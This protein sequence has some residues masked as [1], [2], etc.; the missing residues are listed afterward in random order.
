MRMATDRRQALALLAALGA[1]PL[2]S[3]SAAAT[4][5]GAK[6][7]LLA[8]WQASDREHIGQVKLGA[9]EWA[10]QHVLEVPT[11]AHGLA[12]EAGG[13]VLAVARRPGDWL[14]RW[15]PATGTTQWHWMEED[16]RF[17]GHVAADAS[18]RH[19]WT[20]ETE[21]EQAQGLVGLRDARSLEKT[22]EWSTHG[23]DPHQL[24][25]LPESLG[26][27]S[28]GAL[29]V[30]NGG[31]MALPETGRTKKRLNEMDASLVVMDPAK[32]HLLGQWRLP[33]S[34]LSIRHLAW[35]PRHRRLGIALQ[36]E[37]PLA[38]ERHAAPVLAVWDGSSLRI[39]ANQPPMAGY[40][41]DIVALPAGG[42]AVSCPR[43][44]AIA[45]FGP[46]G[47]WRA[48]LSLPGAYALAREAEQWWAGGLPQI[49]AAG[50]ELLQA[51]S[52]LQSLRWD[53][54]WVPAA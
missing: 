28:A 46:D 22:S 33:D 39:A 54:H 2:G 43:V 47:A 51:P 30:A 29:V 17:N 15:S 53:N 4:G 7:T 35:D 11:R 13:T 26:R 5:K 6:G 44:N 42:F 50:G 49:R 1:I 21:L 24:M 14:V 36:A 37:H 3:A 40:G 9:A 31:I 12:S 20:T 16:R 52:G 27:F 19:L 48:N 45:T 34:Y 18:G 23:H 10:L 32:G 25:A 38:D 41:G 8:A